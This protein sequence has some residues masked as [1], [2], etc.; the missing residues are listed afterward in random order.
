MKKKFKKKKDETTKNPNHKSNEKN[1]NGNF[2]Q[3]SGYPFFHFKLQEIFKI[4]SIHNIIKL[5]IYHCIECKII[6]FS[7]KIE[8]LNTIMYMISKLIY[9][10]TDSSSVSSIISISKNK[11]RRKR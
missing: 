1:E 4:V 9:P 2:N 6:F 5:I 8:I 11:R 3:L 7:Y 10:C